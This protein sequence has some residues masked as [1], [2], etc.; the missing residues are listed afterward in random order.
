MYTLLKQ[1][2]KELHQHDID[3]TPKNYAKEFYK[4]AE[5]LQLDIEDRKRLDEIIQTL[6]QFEKEVVKNNKI[7]T[8]TELVEILKDR[9]SEAEIM[10]FVTH[11]TE[12]LKPSIDQKIF[13]DVE[14]L[15]EDL[16]KNPKKLTAEDTLKKIARI[17]DARVKCDRQAI[18]EKS[19]DMKKLTSLLSKY[20]DK[21]LIQSCNTSE[22][23]AEIKD[24]I[25]SLSLSDQS[26]RELTS[27]QKQLVD[28]IFKL[29]NSLEKNKM[30]LIKGQDQCNVFETQIKELQMELAEVKKE[31]FVD[32][33]TGVLNRR[34]FDAEIEKFENAYKLFNSKYAIFFYDIDD[35]K[36]VND[37]YGHDCGDVILNT[38]GS[39]LNKL[40]REDDAISRYGGEEFVALLHYKDEDEIKRYAQRVK[41]LI[42]KNK[43]VY[44]N[45]IKLKLK[46]SAGVA[47]RD[48][49]D[50]AKTC[51][52]KADLLLYKAKHGGKDQI[53][54]DNDLIL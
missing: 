26:R 31:K 37:Q 13:K 53:I 5:L 49:Y 35:F 19:E 12:F 51:I 20:Y 6:S 30:D 54:F 34:G 15:M 17:T 41:E 36:K 27:L 46:F 39:I 33:L 11:I 16:K 1:T 2:L 52:K 3:A 50:S 10:S 18:V 45:E 43:F 24:E 21:S 32:Y 9:I 44:K 38:F 47:F 14:Q 40:T 8:A 23:I 29:E 22:E 42:S 25:E 48:Q 28:T 7:N 4:Q